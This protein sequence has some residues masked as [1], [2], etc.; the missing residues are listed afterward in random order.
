MNA[1]DRYDEN[2]REMSAD[3]YSNHLWN[4]LVVKQIDY[5]L[6]VGLIHLINILNKSY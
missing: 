1:K 5:D 3:I 2:I 4:E 6:E